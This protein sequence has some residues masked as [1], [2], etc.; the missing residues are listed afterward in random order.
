ME[1]D[2]CAKIQRTS[3]NY[4]LY[5]IF[6]NNGGSSK[7][8]IKWSCDGLKWF[9]LFCLCQ[10][11]KRYQI[12]KKRPNCQIFIHIYVSHL[13]VD[14]FREFSEFSEYLLGDTGDECILHIFA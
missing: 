8:K 7:N 3:N 14:V 11:V 9:K 10:N 12:V 1:K 13:I 2:T 5:C 4:Y 6:T